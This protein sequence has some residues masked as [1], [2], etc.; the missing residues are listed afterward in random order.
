MSARSFWRKFRDSFRSGKWVFPENRNRNKALRI[1]KREQN[2]AARVKVTAAPLTTEHLDAYLIGG[3]DPTPNPE[4]E[5]R[6]TIRM[7]NE[8]LDSYTVDQIRKTLSRVGVANAS[9]MKR[10]EMHDR[11]HKLSQESQN[12]FWST[13]RHL[14][15]QK[16]AK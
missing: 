4:P 1:I 12:L 16:G 7:T 11:Y 8:C 3:Y 15:R 6:R 14:P 2:R 10:A 13:I 5:N 9:R